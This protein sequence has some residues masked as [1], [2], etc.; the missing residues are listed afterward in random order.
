MEV[1]CC[2]GLVSMAI[3]AIATAGKNIPL[4]E[5]TVKI[6]GDLKI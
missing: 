5:I 4:K 1:P 6:D 2:S 3:Q